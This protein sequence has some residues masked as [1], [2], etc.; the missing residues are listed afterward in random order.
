MKD[1][2]SPGNDGLTKEFYVAFFGFFGELGPTMLKAFNLSFEKGELS[3]SQK[4]SVITL[5]QKKV[6]IPCRLKT[7]GHSL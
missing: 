4:Q 1:G 3:K 6:E 2:R 5:I 7:G